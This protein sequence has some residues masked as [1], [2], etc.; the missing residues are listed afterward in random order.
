MIAHHTVGGCPLRTGDL[1]GSGTISGPEAKAESGS[2][3]EL[4]VNGKEEVEVSGAMRTFLQDGD[5]VTFRGAAGAESARVGFGV[6][7]GSV[8]GSFP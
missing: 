8:K 6:C 4:S 7:T 3:L 2:L 1:L 5:I